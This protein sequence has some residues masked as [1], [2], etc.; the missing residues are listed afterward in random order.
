[1]I[2][3]YVLLI[4]G[5]VFLIKGADWFVAGSSSIARLLR[6]PSV[7]IG[8]TI[9]AFGTSAPELAVSVTAAVNGQNAIAISNVLGSNLFNLM[10]VIG[11]CAA[12]APMKISPKILR[13]EFPFSLLLTLLL[14]VFCIFS[15]S[16]NGF[17]ITR[18]EGIILLILF[19][20]FIGLQIRSAVKS[21]SVAAVDIDSQKTLSPLVSVISIVVG[22]ALIVI[23]GDLV[24]DCASAIAASF[25]LSQTLIGLTIVAL[26]TS[27]PELVT[28]V[29]ASKKGENDLALGNV[30]GSNI[31][32]ILFI[33]G[34]SCTINPIAIQMDSIIDCGILIL[35]T[36]IVF[37]FAKYIKGRN[38]IGRLEGVAMLALYA[39]YMVYII[40]R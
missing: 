11:F 22:I 16:G 1:M 33:L 27:L 7:I 38:N 37:I 39:G 29:V 13:G 30:V 4:V 15:F 20:I 19:A 36:V 14:F 17:A 6:V 2:W 31:F 23:G 3:T 35:F 18:L 21:R 26:G 32:N 40:G 9:V 25:G 8:L 5:F 24:V 12:L 10:V 28:S 34:V